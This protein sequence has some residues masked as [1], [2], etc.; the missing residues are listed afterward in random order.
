VV[1][2]NKLLCWVIG[3]A[4]KTCYFNVVNYKNN[5]SPPHFEWTCMSTSVVINI[6]WCFN[7]H[8]FV[9]FVSYGARYLHYFVFYLINWPFAN[10]LFDFLPTHHSTFWFSKTLNKIMLTFLK[11][12]WASSWKPHEPLNWKFGILNPQELGFFF[13]QQKRRNISYCS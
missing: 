2:W 7:T 5:A 10:F 12:K 11:E 4:N 3:G 6:A 8:R 9:C 13:T 1:T